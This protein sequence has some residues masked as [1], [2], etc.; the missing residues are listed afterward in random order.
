VQGATSYLFLG[1]EQKMMRE[2]SVALSSSYSVFLM[3]DS[4]ELKMMTFGL[5]GIWNNLD[6]S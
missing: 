2:N 4:F 5:K 6:P 3:L 1:D